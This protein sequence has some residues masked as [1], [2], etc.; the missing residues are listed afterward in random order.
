METK[1][2]EVVDFLCTKKSCPFY[3]WGCKLPESK[4]KNCP[5]SGNYRRRPRIDIDDL[6]VVVDGD[7]Y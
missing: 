3:D 2:E 4:K 5:K 7:G 6:L 1:T